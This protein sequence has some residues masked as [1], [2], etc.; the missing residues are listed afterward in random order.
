MPI[1]K[2]GNV[3]VVSIVPDNKVDY[4]EEEMRRRLQKAAQEMQINQTCKNARAI[5]LER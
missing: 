4:S 2:R 5:H 1:I 3:D